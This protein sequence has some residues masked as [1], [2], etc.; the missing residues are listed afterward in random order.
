MSLIHYQSVGKGPALV[1]IHGFCE[2]HEIWNGFAERFSDRYRVI[3]IDL[4]GF[5]LSALPENAISIEDIGAS[6]INLLNDLSLS[7]YTLVGH[8]LGGYVALAMA[9]LQE[10]S[11]TGIVLFHSTPT[12]DTP[13][14]KENRNKVIDFVL[15][16][17]VPPFVETFVPGLFANKNHPAIERVRKMAL[18]TPQNTLLAYT[19]AMRD[20]PARL[21]FVKNFK[22]PGLLLGGAFD[23]IITPQSL[24][25]TAEKTGMNLIFLNECAHMGMLEDPK[26]ASMELKKFLDWIPNGQ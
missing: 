8:S 13:E 25:E 1:F 14:K 5:G 17:G 21:D 18:Q 11:V 15:E 26:A 24:V 10:K 6:V 3:V 23:N 22:K 9:S 7:S 2:T 16:N 12:S 4:P 20:R 19:A